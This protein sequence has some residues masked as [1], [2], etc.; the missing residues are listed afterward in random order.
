[1]LEEIE[2]S[3]ERAA[4]ALVLVRMLDINLSLKTRYEWGHTGV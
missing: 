1:M 4:I 3:V 2:R